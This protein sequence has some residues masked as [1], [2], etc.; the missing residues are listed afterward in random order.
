MGGL[1][2]LASYPKSGNTWLRSF[3]HNLLRNTREPANINELDHFCLGESDARWFARHLSTP[4]DQ[5]PPDLI[6]KMRPFAQAD[7]TQVFPDSVFVKTHNYL[8][9]WHGNPLHNM[10]VT[11]GGIYV[12]R[13][14]LD[15]ALSMTHHFG[16]DLDSAIERL[17]NDGAITEG[18]GGHVPEFHSSWS[19]HV[20]SWTQH[21]NPRLLVLRYEDM[22]A[23]PRKAFKSVTKFLGL[24]PPNERL[25]R[26]IRFSSFKA[27]KAQEEKGGFK[28]RSE[29]AASFFRS[30][31]A[32]Q[33]R[34]ELTPDQVR[35]IIERHR[36]Q[37][38]RFGYIPEDY[39]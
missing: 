31:K 3:L 36:E 1:I 30:G 23:K 2:W 11:V 12:V 25:E 5:A 38:E 27:L 32:A 18:G 7:M 39:R 17:G 10:N 15:V 21:P 13:N 34:E 19:G 8:G 6:M 9:E 14:P 29:H 16:L 4:V 20:K 33:W 26:A 22:L 35:A 24:K 28:E 37:M